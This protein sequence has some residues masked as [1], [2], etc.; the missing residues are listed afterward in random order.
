MASFIWV[1]PISGRSPCPTH[2]A[3]KCKHIQV[4][5]ADAHRIGRMRIRWSPGES[6]AEELP[7]SRNV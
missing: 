5:N 6:P 3:E 4:I 7:S 2:G 1:L